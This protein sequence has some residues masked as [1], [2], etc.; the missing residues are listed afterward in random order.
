MTHKEKMDEII[1]VVPR[2]ALFEAESIAF[3]GTE[4]NT[5]RVARLTENIAKNFGTMRRGDAEE[6]PRF[7]QPIPYAVIR[8]GDELFVYERLKGG[9][10]KR[11]HYKLSLGVGGHM[12]YESGM[13]DFNKIIK[14][15]L[16]RELEE[17]LF[18][19]HPFTTQTIGFIN[20][21]SEE[22]S[23]VH[24]GVLTIIDLPLEATV[25]VREKD[26]LR[27]SWTTLEE[28]KKPEVYDRLESWSQI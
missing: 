5:K 25:E 1:I 16:E 3:Q 20:D 28:L 2:M 13:R 22:V 4:S 7:K 11:L 21:D 15:N 10:E 8:R 6:N 24:I 17:E 14:A 19:S 9:G 18:I 12:N 26:Q 23:K 27:G